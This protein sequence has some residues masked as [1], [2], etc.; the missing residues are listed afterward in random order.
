MNDDMTSLNLN[1]DSKK[2]SSFPGQNQNTTGPFGA[3]ATGVAPANPQT[4]S[5]GYGTGPSADVA[6]RNNLLLA[7]VGG[8]VASIIGAAIWG[9]I[10]AVTHFRFGLM[11]IALGA[12]VGFA[13][14]EL[15]R[16][17]DIRFGVIGAGF[18]FFGSLLGNLLAGCAAASIQGH[19]D[20]LDILGGLAV[21]PSAAADFLVNSLTP[22]GALIY[23]IAIYEG[24][25]FS[26]RP[27]R[28]P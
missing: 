20:F 28:N 4:A 3:T 19:G 10:V 7:I 25:K 22:I 2:S 5:G 11:G 1:D 6:G 26:V 13:V 17:N 9:G 15:G 14:R 27:P 21:N 12:F 16:G 8:F 24:Y 23:I 18:S